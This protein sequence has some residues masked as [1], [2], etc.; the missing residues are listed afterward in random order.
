MEQ[1]SSVGRAEAQEGT[2]EREGTDPA[3]E[4]TEQQVGTAG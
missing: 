1:G 3:A 4:Q 2:A